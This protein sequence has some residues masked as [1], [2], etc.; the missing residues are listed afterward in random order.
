MSLYGSLNTNIERNSRGYLYLLPVPA[1]LPTGANLQA[2]IRADFDLFLETGEW[3]DMLEAVKA[4]GN[5]TADGLQ[6][7]F[8]Q[9]R[10]QGES[11][12]QSKHDIGIEDLEAT[13]DFT[14]IDVDPKKF[15]DLFALDTDEMISGAASSTA[16][17][18]DIAA[19]GGQTVP[20]R[21]VALWRAADGNISGEFEMFLWP[22]VTISPDTEL[23]LSKKERVEGK[24]TLTAEEDFNV[25]NAR[26][27]PE[28]CFY[29]KPNAAK[30]A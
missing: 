25:L 5:I 6:A 22:R 2:K 28:K 18:F 30:T 26:G 3:S 17:G 15:A 19:L 23:K 10:L 24:F 13:A 12:N 4:Y 1:T 21:F 16:P 8:K 27:F 14:L 11:N 29:F 20:K 9:N 7:K